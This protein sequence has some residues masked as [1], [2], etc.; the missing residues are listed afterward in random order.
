L[1]HLVNIVC[2]CVG[3][4]YTTND[5]NKLYGM[6]KKNCSLPFLFTC[7]SDQQ[8]DVGNTILID[9]SLDLET[10]W[11]KILI[12]QLGWDEPTIYF[13]LDVIIQNNFDHLFNEIKRNK[14]VSPFISDMTDPSNYP[15][16]GSE[17][18]ILVIPPAIV[19]TSFMGLYPVDH[20]TKYS[21]F[22]NNLDFY[23]ITCLGLDRYL[24]KYFE[25]SFIK[26][27]FANDW[28]HRTK[29]YEY[30]NRYI[31]KYGWV[32]DPR[33][34]ICI[35]SQATSEHYLGMEKYFL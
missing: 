30:D 20:K 15:Y 6:V 3:E 33:K 13:D 19:N 22:I 7:I 27:S 16:D 11:W 35:L 14:I 34:T 25:D 9:T 1:K 8:Q 12:F 24:F 29:C 18:N 21:H 28:Y 5:V 23:I 26:L 31:D 32:N 4:K 17:D 2:V 10:Y